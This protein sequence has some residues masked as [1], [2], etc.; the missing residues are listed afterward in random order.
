MVG[1]A[2]KSKGCHTCRKRKKGC[3]LAR[4][5][6]GQ[7]SKSGKICGGYQ[8]DL[9]FIYH[10]IPGRN[11]QPSP[12]PKKHPWQATSQL[13]GDTSSSTFS[14]ENPSLSSSMSSPSPTASTYD[15]WQRSSAL[16]QQRS[17]SSSCLQVLSPS[18]TLTALTALHTSLFNSCFLPRDY[19]TTP[20]SVGLFGHAAN[21]TRL[22][23]PLL[24]NDLSLQLGYLAVSSS[25][26]GHN[27]HDENLLAASKVFYGKALREMQRAISD[28]QRRYR[29]ETLLACS[30]LSIY[31]M[32]E[33]HTSAAMRV[34]SAPNGWLLHAAAVSRLLEARGPQNYTTDKGHSVFLHA[35][36]PIIIRASTARRRCFLSEPQWL[37]VPWKNP[38]QRIC[39]RSCLI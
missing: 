27:N 18:L 5:V 38:I 22:I 15:D 19:I 12:E 20:E 14:D 36:V 34:G 24:N 3:D 13:E 30:T 7:C 4:P 28:P 33:A 11:Q 29:E 9:T 1:V 2:G 8:K 16:V 32:F 31:E 35:R 37:T 21:W 25:R 26:I 6:C 17:S 10:K 39:S 23:P